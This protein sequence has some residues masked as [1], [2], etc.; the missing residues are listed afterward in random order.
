MATL[1]LVF[2]DGQKVVVP[3]EGRITIGR[4]D[5]NDVVVDDERI[6]TNHAELLFSADGRVE[7][8]TLEAG[9][10]VLV[11]DQAVQSQTIR[12]GDT[13]A[14]GPLKARLDDLEDSATALVTESIRGEAERLTQAQAAVEEAVA[15]HGKWIAAI[16][17]LSVQH[18]EQ[19]VALQKVAAAK[20]ATQ[21][22][23]ENL[24]AS[25]KAE[26]S[27]LQDLRDESARE[28]KRLSDLRQQLSEVEIRCAT[29]EARANTLQGQARTAEKKLEQL[30]HEQ[31]EAQESLMRLQSE[32]A[33]RADDLAAETRRLDEVRA[34]L[35]ETEAKCQTLAPAEKQ[36]AQ[37]QASLAATER[38]E[39]ELK[40]AILKAQEQLA[41]QNSALHKATSDEA[42][43][44]AR[45]QDL[46]ARDKSLRVELE[47]SGPA[48]EKVRSELAGLESRLTPLRD[49]KKSMDQRFARL[50]TLAK[51]SPEE[52][53][54][55]HEI[56]AAHAALFDLLPAAQ[57]KTPGLT[58][59]EFA[60]IGSQAGVPMKSDRIRRP[61]S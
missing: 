13:L 23:I 4:G 37:M 2:E 12:Q 35:A 28:E 47:T 25:H 61:S 30:A 11:N 36:L 24:A 60:R 43:A 3:L 56:E 34:R 19:T 14:F 44:Q 42:A 54:L 18:D 46:T 57:I 31:K 52:K 7:V 17:D 58:R 20:S 10:E 1:T 29:D 27:R 45:I 39:S 21:K 22:E 32:V 48:I 16:Q 26:Q 55:W 33:A 40:T 38:R 51:G 53:N 49:W 41:A 5:D 15:A 9:T 59:I 50:N 8:R 6:S